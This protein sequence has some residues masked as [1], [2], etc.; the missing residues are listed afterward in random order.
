MSADDIH[1]RID[2]YLGI[3]IEGWSAWKLTTRIRHLMDVKQT[4]DNHIKRYR[5]LLEL[6]YPDTYE[7][8]S[9]DYGI[10]G[11]SE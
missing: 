9:R 3:D 1:I 10:E 5:K 11:A 6:N 8:I 2:I 4:L 7:E